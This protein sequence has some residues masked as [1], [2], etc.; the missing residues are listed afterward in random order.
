MLDHAWGFRQAHECRLRAD[1]DVERVVEDPG[2]PQPAEGSWATGNPAFVGQ[3]VPP[4]HRVRSV[5]GL[6]GPRPHW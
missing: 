4:S 5:R 2:I 6:S 3:L 1:A